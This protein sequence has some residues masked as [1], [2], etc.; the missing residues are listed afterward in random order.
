[1]Y[2]P[3]ALRCVLA[4]VVLFVATARQAFSQV[5]ASDNFN[6]PAGSFLNGQNGGTGWGNAWS[7]SSFGL[8]NPNDLIPET[9]Q[10]GSLSFATLATSG[11]R[12]QTGGKFSYD[13]RNLAS[14]LGT[15]GTTRYASFLLSR[16]TA[17]P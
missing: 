8:N 17:G 3:T 14:S 2:R 12:V 13:I 7:E 15:S 11:N 6:Y 1:M 10:P 5:I 4:G 9:I 16:V